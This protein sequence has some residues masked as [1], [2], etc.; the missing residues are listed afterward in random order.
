MYRMRTL[1]VGLTVAISLGSGAA[2]LAPAALASVA[3]PAS[4]GTFHSWR[5][6]Q[7]A[8]GFGLI[9]PGNTYGLRRNGLISVVPC[10]A[11]GSFLSGPELSLRQDNASTPCGNFG[12]ARVLGHYR[13]QGRRATLYGVCGKHLGPPCSSRRI[14]MY[15]TW[16]KHGNYYEASSHNERR[17]TIV[18]FARSLHRV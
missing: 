16:R 2:A 17:H 8:A 15:L 10:Q 6:A 14:T 12:A 3:R 5:A 11:S 1:A 9:R 7:R 13:V 4:V 18:G